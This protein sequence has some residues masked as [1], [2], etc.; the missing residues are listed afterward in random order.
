M[1][2]ISLG[3]LGVFILLGAS[4]CK[5]SEPAAATTGAAKPSIPTESG[6]KTKLANEAKANAER[7]NKRLTSDPYGNLSTTKSLSAGDG[8]SS[9]VPRAKGVLPKISGAHLSILG[10]PIA[11]VVQHTATEAGHF[12]LGQGKLEI[13]VAQVKATELKSFSAIFV[14]A[15]LETVTGGP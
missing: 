14:K 5:I 9:Y 11:R 12:R 13:P 8:T 15:G 6:T 2:R 1:K 10:H 4:S 7:L 3:L